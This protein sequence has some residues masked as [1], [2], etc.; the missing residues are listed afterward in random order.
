M[1][2]QQVEAYVRCPM[3]RVD[4]PMERTDDGTWLNP[5]EHRCEPTRDVVPAR[6]IGMRIRFP[7]DALEVPSVGQEVDGQ[8]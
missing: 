5:A 1:N 3:C 6:S 7:S 4:I 8:N 2:D